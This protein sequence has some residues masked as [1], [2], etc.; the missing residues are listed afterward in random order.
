MSE[1]GKSRL[2][3]DTVQ[4]GR[5]V[6]TIWR[7]IWLP[8]S[9]YKSK[10][11][12]KKN[13]ERYSGEREGTGTAGECVIW[14]LR[15]WPELFAVKANCRLWW[16]AANQSNDFCAVVMATGMPPWSVGGRKK[17][18]RFRWG[19]AGMRDGQRAEMLHYFNPF[20]VACFIGI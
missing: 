11:P 17:R 6:P 18:S 1:S 20:H 9:G 3:C 19:G 13:A 5:K 16:G 10:R 7:N 4:H 12:W 8:F 15:T 2:K 14:C